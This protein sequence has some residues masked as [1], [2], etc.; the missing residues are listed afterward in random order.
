MGNTLEG[1]DTYYTS[2]LDESA[3]KFGER[4][5]FFIEEKRGLRLWKDIIEKTAISKTILQSSRKANRTLDIQSTAMLATMLNFTLDELIQYCTGEVFLRVDGLFEYKSSTTIPELFWTNL[6]MVRESRKMRWVDIAE[7]TRLPKST[8]SS[9]KSCNQNLSFFMAY[10]LAVGVDCSIS[11]LC[12]DADTKLYYSPTT[13]LRDDI[14]KGIENF[15]AS[16]L[17][18]IYEMVQKMQEV[19]KVNEKYLKTNDK[20][21]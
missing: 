19:H 1:T 5:W 13:K 4:F 20:E 14:T 11:C 15:S 7:K 17:Q 2:N 16:E 3:E 18:P 8:I 10:R 6:D 9:A 21:K 12:G